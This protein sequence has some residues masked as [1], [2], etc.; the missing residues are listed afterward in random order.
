MQTWTLRFTNGRWTELG[1]AGGM[2]ELVLYF[3]ATDEVETGAAY[4]RLREAFPEAL[5]AGASTGSTI[6]G[7]TVDDHEVV[8]VAVRFA[9]TRVRAA[10]VT[11]ADKAG[12]FTS[13]RELAQALAA[14][15]LVAVFV[16]ADGLCIN[17]SELVNGLV[18]VLGDTVSL[19]GGMA[20]DGE[21]FGRT[22]VGL[23]DAPRADQVVAIGFYGAKLRVA[24]AAAGG[25]DPFGPPRTITA[26][27]GN[28]LSELDGE[29]ALDLYERYLGDEAQGLPGTALLYPMKIWPPENPA[30]STVRTI[31]AVDH[32]ARTM[33]FAGD[34]P[35][36]WHAQLMRGVHEHLV[37]GAAR[38]AQA[39][40]A[41]L[42]RAEDHQGLALLVS[43]V[44]RRL[45]M[46]Q[47]TADEIEAM[48]D[49][50]GNQ[51]TQIGFYSYGEI[52]PHEHHGASDLHN[53]TMTVTLLE[54][55][56]A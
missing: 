5:I 23:N 55:V 42:G 50:F 33:T 31:L 9:G 35:Q 47:R 24:P 13:G 38:A 43:C 41:R 44:G 40:Q 7:S 15:D 34:I 37:G 52:A 36:G 20:G 14:P 26:A 3:G 32:D 46:G 16:L 1:H 18:D 2:P 56:E 8:A 45:L 54:E 25:W 39:A 51:V 28:V 6:L 10:C 22:V 53:Q 49:W 12:S 30:A 4:M 19:S 21:R 17:G 48:A 29:A 11:V 27:A